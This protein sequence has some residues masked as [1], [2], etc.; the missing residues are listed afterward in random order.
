MVYFDDLKIIHY[1]KLSL[2]FAFKDLGLT[3]ILALLV[4]I[5]L[6]I[7]YLLGIYLVLIGFSLLIYLTIKLTKKKYQKISERN[8]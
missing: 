8:K 2:I 1:V 4:I 6:F 3:L 7:C 5:T